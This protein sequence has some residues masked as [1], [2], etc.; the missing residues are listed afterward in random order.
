M[1][2]MIGTLLYDLGSSE[3]HST[4]IKEMCMSLRPIP[5]ED[6]LRRGLFYNKAAN[7]N[8]QTKLLD[9]SEV[10]QLDIFRQESC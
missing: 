4:F 5:K 9:R 1:S 2:V 7:R 10:T 8:W 6:A 3:R